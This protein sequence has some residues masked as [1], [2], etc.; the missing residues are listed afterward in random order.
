MWGGPPTNVV[1][2][3][4]E[5]AAEMLRDARADAE[6]ILAERLRAQAEDEL[7]I[8]TDRRRRE[9][10]RLAEAARRQPR[11]PRS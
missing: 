3:A 9:A 2:L 1:R 8:Y 10:D 5:R 6:R 11:P 7:R 4:E